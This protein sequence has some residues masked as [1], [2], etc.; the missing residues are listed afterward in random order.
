[1]NT[2][3]HLA[4]AACAAYGWAVAAAQRKPTPLRAGVVAGGAA[5]IGLLSHFLLDLIPHYAWIAN[6]DWFQTLP[7][8]WLLCE[9]LFGLAVAVPAL[10]IARGARGHVAL[11]MLGGLY[12]DL[13]KVMSLDL[14]V[15]D[16][17]VLFAWHSNHLSHRT[18]GCSKPILAAFECALVLALLWEMWRIRARD[19]RYGASGAGR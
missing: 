17:Y 3:A 19:A 1:V 15:P 13:E 16:R 8:R 10:L 2:T 9:G 7:Y 12:P 14:H 6:L 4:G 5:V 18:G 11:G